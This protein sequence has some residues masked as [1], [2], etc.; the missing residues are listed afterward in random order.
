MQKFVLDSSVIL[1]WLNEQD[2]ER[3]KEAQLILEHAVKGKI[4]I[5]APELAKYEVGNILL[6]RKKLSLSQIKEVFDFLYGLPLKYF[7]ETR[8]SQKLTYELA[9]RAKI[10]YYDA[11]FASLAKL[12]DATLITD[13]PKHQTR[14]KRVKVIALEDYK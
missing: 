5:L 6:I 11:S 8:S 2:E 10:T 4:E 12:E 7:S 13:N 1:K 3:I 14:V 9:S